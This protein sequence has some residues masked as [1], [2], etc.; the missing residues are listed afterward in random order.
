MKDSADVAEV[1]QEGVSLIV[2]G[3]SIALLGSILSYAVGYAFSFVVARGIGPS[4]YG[5]YSLGLA[6]S[7]LLTTLALLGL[8]RAA[9]RYIALYMGEADVERAR[10]TVYVSSLIVLLAGSVLGIGLVGL[11]KPLSEQLFAKPALA[12]PLRWFGIAL[13]FG[14]L[15][16]ILMS[17]LQGLKVLK[18]R[19]YVESFAQPCTRLGV[20]AFLIYFLGWKLQGVLLAYL[21]AAVIGLLLS[22][23]LLSRVFPVF[24]RRI[25]LRA[26]WRSLLSFSSPLF[27][28]SGLNMIS[29]QTE[30]FFLG[31][32]D[33]ADTVGIYAV[34]LRTIALGTFVQQ[35]FH[36]I[37]APVVSDL[38]NRGQTKRLGQFFKFVSRWIFVLSMPCF[39]AIAM[40]AAPIL[41]IFGPEYVAG[42]MAV[43]LLST[44]QLVNVGVGP[45]GLVLMMSGRPRITLINSAIMLTLNIVLDYLLIPT[46]GIIGAAAASG[47][48]FAIT[49]VVALAEVRLLLHLHPYGLAHLKSLVAAVIALAV[50][51]I[52]TRYGLGV[53]SLGRL[54]LQLSLFG[55]IYVVAM[56]LQGLDQEDTLLKVA[57]VRRLSSIRLYLKDLKI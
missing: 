11:A 5:L 31:V 20:A 41:N 32:F 48:S 6:I 56:C 50:S 16:M 33:R 21:A 46:Y 43:I 55:S 9:I 53:A 36:A 34:A 10:S 19:V 15:V 45:A 27:I 2:K 4:L 13:P 18:Y 14:A 22:V 23:V 26:E 54:G 51:Y 38:H 40:F 52:S 8:D 7:S 12:S 1:A 47:I 44:A 28:A 30:L 39:L 17:T 42:R 57:L 24:E 29:A 3:A 35:S 25:S 49:N 37:F